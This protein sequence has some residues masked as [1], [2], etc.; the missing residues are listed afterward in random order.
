M[1]VRRSHR[2]IRLFVAL[3]ALAVTSG[4][5]AACNL[6]T[7]LDA[8]Y[9]SSAHDGAAAVGEGG[10]ADGSADGSANAD[11]SP[12][13]DGMAGADADAGL[14][15]WCRSMQDGSADNDF[16]CTDFEN[17][18]FPDGG[19]PPA[20]WN[21]ADNDRDAGALRFV[22]VD[23]SR[24]LDV[25]SSSNGTSGA[26]TRLF[27]ALSTTNSHAYLHYQLDYDF[28]VLQANMQY[29]AVGLLMFANTSSSSKEHGIAAYGPGPPVY[30]SQ[31]GGT[32]ALTKKVPNDG[33]WHHATITLDRMAADT[34]YTRAITIDG[35]SGINV[36]GDTNGHTIDALDPTNISVGV[37]N[38]AS[39]AGTAHVQID[40]IVFRRKQ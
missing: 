35:I 29:A 9:S 10:S 12:A 13:S 5:V 31:Q 7:G 18:V 27:K 28:C 39:A 22:D 2:T 25:T 3:A 4:A 34:T 11:G 1:G 24:V 37:F 40:N 6:I 16:F 23:A 14:V 33:D 21:T 20:G 38:S 26:Q 19:G 8:D 30:L 36:D 32:G 17:A 15:T